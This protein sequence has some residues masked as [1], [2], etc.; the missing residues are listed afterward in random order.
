M[1]THACVYIVYLYGR[2]L[3]VTPTPEVTPNSANKLPTQFKAP[4]SSSECKILDVISKPLTFAGNSAFWGAVWGP[5]HS[6]HPL[7][8]GKGAILN[9]TRLTSASGY[10]HYKCHITMLKCRVWGRGTGNADEWEALSHTHTHTHT[11]THK[12]ATV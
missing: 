12:Q 2:I 7:W 8:Q 4:Y 1:Q 9:L 3:M 5:V 6:L 11:H 10:K